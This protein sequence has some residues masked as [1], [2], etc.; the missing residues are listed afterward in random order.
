MRL[1]NKCPELRVLSFLIFFKYNTGMHFKDLFQIASPD[2]QVQTLSEGH[3]RLSIPAGRAGSYRV[4]QLDDYH[5]LRRTDFNWQQPLSFSC[6]IRASGQDLPG[7]WGVGLW[8]DPFGFGI[9]QGAVRLLPAFPNAAWFFFASEPNYLSFRD[10]VPAVGQLA[11]VFRSPKL[12]V[13]AFIPEGIVLAPL[14]LIPPA[15][16]WLRRLASNLIQED[17]ASLTLDPREWHHYQIDWGEDKV[18]FWV[19]GQTVFE[20]DCLPN[21]PLGL[22]LWIDNQYAAWGP[23]GRLKYGTLQSQSAWIEIRELKVI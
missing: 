4:A 19:D 2:A 9:A 22:V 3:W 7:T 6:E 16:R 17:A 18:S 23:D 14:L 11:G 1:F 20:T 15:A 8:N 21:G 10:D 12:P 13:W 5:N